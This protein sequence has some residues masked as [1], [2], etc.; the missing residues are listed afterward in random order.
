MTKPFTQGF[1][2]N[3]IIH[4]KALTIHLDL[5]KRVV[6]FSC[7]MLSILGVSWDSGVNCAWPGNV[8]V[9]ISLL[10]LL[11]G[12]YCHDSELGAGN[13]MWHPYLKYTL[14]V[15]SLLHYTGIS[16]TPAF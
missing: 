2:T 9:N 16:I 8:A 3:E 12:R 4:F 14:N 11:L 5:N 13:K 15:L 6:F 1:S 10:Y 7:N